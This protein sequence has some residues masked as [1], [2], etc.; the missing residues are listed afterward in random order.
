MEI[1]LDKLWDQIELAKKESD[2]RFFR[3]LLEAGEFLIK[4]TTAA[5]ISGIDEDSEGTR[6]NYL[7]RL[8]RANSIGEWVQT[9]Q[10]AVK[11]VP[12]QLLS[13]ELRLIQTELNQKSNDS[14]QNAT[15][16]QLRECIH[17]VTKTPIEHRG[18]A[19]LLQ[20]FVAFA[21]LRN[22][23]NHGAVRSS[24]ASKVCGRL[25]DTLL[26]FRRLFCLFE[27]DW[28]Y[29]HKNYSGTIQPQWWSQHKPIDNEVKE[30]IDR[31]H[32]AEGVYL[33]LGGELK[34]IELM[35]SDLDENVSIANGDY[36]KRNNDFESLS[37]ITGDLRRVQLQLN[38][39]Q[40]GIKPLSETSSATDL[41][42]TGNCLHNLP[43]ATRNY[44]DR[45]VLESEL[46]SLLSNDYTRIVT[47]RGLGG[48]G[49]TTLALSTL[50]DITSID[51]FLYI[52][53]FSSRDVDLIDTGPT[54]VKPDVK[55]LREIAEQ[56]HA[57]INPHVDVPNR[58][59]MIQ[60]FA[61]ALQSIREDPTLFV[62]DNFE[63]LSN[64]GDVYEFIWRN[65]RLP[66]KVLITTR[67]RQTFNEDRRVDVGG[68][69]AEESEKLIGHY[70]KRFGINGNLTKNQIDRIID[71]S[72][73][74]PYVMQL[75]LS[76]FA[77]TSSIP[78][79]L[80]RSEST[81]S[82]LFDLTYAQLTEGATRLF[83]TLAHRNT[84]FAG[85]AIELV[86]FYA[87]I[88]F[89]VIDAIAELEQTSLI[90]VR[91]VGADQKF[92]LMPAP[93]RLF[94]KSKLKVNPMKPD[95]VRDWE[96][97]DWFGV[98]NESQIRLGVMP[99][100][101]RF[102]KNVVGSVE[103]REKDFEHYRSLLEYLGRLYPPCCLEIASLFRDR[104]DIDGETYFV[105]LYLTE[106]Q[107]P[108]LKRAWEWLAAIQLRRGRRVDELSIR[109]S[110]V[111]NYVV[112]FNDISAAAHAHGVVAG[113]QLYAPSERKKMEELAATLIDAM[114]ARI[115]E[116]DAT[117]C[118]RLAWMCHFV[119][120]FESAKQWCAHGLDLDRH[121]HH[122]L[123][124]QA[125]LARN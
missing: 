44:V 47:L 40:P 66:N 11:R 67:H 6:N 16:T 104:R 90:D 63:T 88:R 107:G 101:V 32:F 41:Q 12:S 36:N 91:T 100:I 112:S 74:H 89:N 76:E 42:E 22:K 78:R 35:C 86:F 108:E 113:K 38:L 122:C 81:L 27:Y 93:A 96:L 52:L 119:R 54:P 87:G 84:C 120:D 75:M 73:G 26:M 18:K 124:L 103:R 116:A 68:M 106:G 77:R 45:N 121:N 48:I 56:Y 98:V 99:L 95:V 57:L 13:E 50:H 72:S 9:L 43:P 55:T 69:S 39:A 30:N 29:L 80:M 31:K 102:L 65:I 8:V 19:N 37:Y 33:N 94:G 34:R 51:R 3:V 82:S 79:G 5:Y 25:S 97:L 62:F 2:Y 46:S 114:E 125:G 53:W 21:E 111:E 64:I 71:D 49:K 15:A 24:T 92:V 10:V 117:D 20:F 105:E 7:Y 17:V 110:M 70:S 59:V 61:S 60:Q 4:V 28:V 14:W 83:L 58:D 118:S 1:I 123:G 109:V 23:V 85:L 115:R